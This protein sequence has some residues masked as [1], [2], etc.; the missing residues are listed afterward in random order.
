M[1]ASRE[2][3]NHVLSMSISVVAGLIIHDKHYKIIDLYGRNRSRKKLRL[4]VE[5]LIHA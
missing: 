1:C 3:V 5:V 2:T 4:E